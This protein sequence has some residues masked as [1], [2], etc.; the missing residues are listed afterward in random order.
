MV[1]FVTLACPTCGG[2]LEITKD[3]QRFA[4]GH[5]GNEHVVLRQGGIVAL[6][7][8]EQEIGQIQKNT[9]RTASELAVKRL[10]EEL[11]QLDKD[12]E[13]LLSRAEIG[14]YWADLLT[15]KTAGFLASLSEKKRRETVESISVEQI[16][17]IAKEYKASFAKIKSPNKRYIDDIEALERLMFLKTEIPK[18]EALLTKHLKFLDS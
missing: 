15:S 6:N 16:K 12:Y 14:F 1:E 5:C 8:V 4:C 13:D 11:E 9:D 18:K 10:R 17:S 2:K 7:P 3:I